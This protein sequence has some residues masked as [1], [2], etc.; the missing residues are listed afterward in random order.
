MGR[1]KQLFAKYVLTTMVSSVLSSIYVSV[2]GIFIGQAVGD[3]GLTAVNIIW[4]IEAIATSLARGIGIG[5]AICMSTLFGKDDKENAYQF[6]A[7]A[8]CMLLSVYLFM[9]VVIRNLYPFLLVFF[10]ATKGTEI[11][12]MSEDYTRLYVTGCLFQI[13]GVGFQPFLRNANKPIQAM[14][15]QI[16]GCITN[17]IL[18]Y[19]FVI[20]WNWE[21]KGAGLATII[22]QS[23]V[24][25]LVLT[26]FFRDKADPL[27]WDQFRLKGKKM[28]DIISYSITPTGLNMSNSVIIIFYNRVCLLYGGVTAAAAYSVVNYS[29]A[30][31]TLF[32]NGIGEGIQP[33][34][35]FNYGK[36]DETAVK[37]YMKLAKKVIL[38]IGVGITV[39]FLATRNYVGVL[40]GASED[41]NTIVA[42]AIILSAFMFPL[43]GFVR[44]YMSSFN[45]I[46]RNLN[47]N[48]LVYSEAL[49]FTPLALMILPKF[50][51]MD[52]IWISF[53]AVQIILMIIAAAFG[54]KFKDLL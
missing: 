51:G 43:K 37:E 39:I 7:N 29:Y 38:V 27:R 13:L 41:A 44:L 45:A 35:S 21:V 50:F 8:I 17:I 16:T 54:K 31:G 49:V 1:N 34:I 11:Y 10:G 14:L 52:G 53:T 30:A 33:L 19:I 46:G 5:G 23:F 6:R 18:D 15:Y 32:V 48:L 40:F 24:C 28:L 2:D 3:N 36:K 25:I 9:A 26:T 20:K 22:G 42:Q 12:R 47:S 4:P